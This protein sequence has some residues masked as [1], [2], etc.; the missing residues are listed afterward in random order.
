MIQII[1]IIVGFYHDDHLG[2]RK[3]VPYFLVMKKYKPLLLKFLYGY[4]IL[5]CI[6]QICCRDERK[7]KVK[8]LRF[9]N[10]Y[11]HK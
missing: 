5:F 4:Q 11:E 10:R 2:D 7:Q 9:M 6:N 3:Y 8:P 1:V